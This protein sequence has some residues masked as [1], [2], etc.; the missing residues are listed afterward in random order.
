MDTPPHRP[1]ECGAV[2]RLQNHPVVHRHTAAM[3]NVPRKGKAQLQLLLTTRICQRLNCRRGNGT[4]IG[5]V[6]KC[7]RITVGAMIW[8]RFANARA[9]DLTLSNSCSLTTW[10]GLFAYAVW[11]T[12][13]ETPTE[14]RTT[15]ARARRGYGAGHAPTDTRPCFKCCVATVTTRSSTA[16]LARVKANRT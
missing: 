8:P 7:F 5:S 4:E 11:R 15:L 10:P 3:H 9:A 14:R 12:K 13:P 6:T 1:E 2:R 16:R